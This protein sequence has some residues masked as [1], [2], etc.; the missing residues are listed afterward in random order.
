MAEYQVDN[1]QVKSLADIEKEPVGGKARWLH[2][3]IEIGLEVPEGLVIYPAKCPEKLEGHEK[4]EE[5]TVH[6]AYRD[7]G[8]GIAAVRSSAEDEDSDH[9]S[10][11]GQYETFL[12]VEGE[13][14]IARAVTACYESAHSERVS[15]Y[16]NEI[17][18]SGS[19]PQGA[20]HP[21]GPM[22][23][24]VQR[25]IEPAKA[26][27][28]F[29]V[30]PVTDS[31]ETLIIEAVSGTGDLLVSGTEAG[32]RYEI[33]RRTFTLN[34]G[35]V[36]EPHILTSAEIEKLTREALYAEEKL[37][38]SL[39]MEWAIDRSGTLFW[40]QARPITTGR[41][42]SLD[43][44][45]GDDELLTRCNIGEMLP[46]AATPLTLSVFAEPLDW[47]LQEMS[48]R[49]GVLHGLKK[50]PRYINH[51]ENHL[52]M[53]LT[54]MY[55]MA[56]RVAGATREGTELNIIG[57]ILPEHDIGPQDPGFF[58]VLNGF[59]YV[60]LLFRHN[61]FLKKITKT[62]KNFTIDLE[63]RSAYELYQELCTLQRSVLNKVYFYHYCVS[64]FSGAM[65]AILA[66]VIAGDDEVDSAA[67]SRMSLLLTD[68]P[69]IESAHILEAIEEIALS[70]EKSGNIDWFTA[71]PE[72]EILKWL[73]TDASGVTGTLFRQF[74]SRHGHR[75]IREA[76]L[77]S[78]DYETY[79]EELIKIIKD[80][81]ESNKTRKLFRTASLKAGKAE[82]K[83]DGTQQTED[84]KAVSPWLLK[85]AKTG[86]RQREFSKSMLI[87]AQHQ[88]KKG[89]RKLAEILVNENKLPDKDLIYFFTREEI[90]CLIQGEDRNLL[91]RK[92]K[93]RRQKLP[94]QMQLVFPEISRGRPVPFIR[95]SGN[96]S[97][98]KTITGTPVS[99][100]IT[101]GMV[102]IVNHI[103]EAYQLEP[104]EIMVA[105]FTDI[106]WT[107]FFSTISGLVTEIGGALSHGAVV[108]REYGLP[109]VSNIPGIINLL[110]TGM[111]I[112]LDG[113]AG[114]IH[115]LEDTDT[116]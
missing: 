15:S 88:F 8:G 27:V 68:I 114:T 66:A 100:G 53:N 26:G 62:A 42:D 37:G 49:E 44:P 58:R 13:K 79:P 71:A 11:A 77:R 38:R 21:P 70:I 102:R 87:L 115:I 104:G 22:A 64:A 65:N 30:D 25:M 20:Y 74:L 89:Y 50:P 107:P 35:G 98:G 41:Q 96:S 97:P 48:R 9:A 19:G 7:V 109:M 111:K 29:T 92:A 76:E 78:K 99:I 95:E 106:G 40:L 63:N 36:K 103:D 112:Q 23:V 73:E 85:Q 80:T 82:A 10:A 56:R 18:G 61:R 45:I 67:H 59:R 105:P 86:V 2:R 84:E 91:I 94:Y 52:F 32:Q 46:G 16:R 113:K 75:C 28:V 93:Q 57:R 116:E 12:R 34:E 60:L 108:A 5:K 54:S 47:G 3:L 43:T 90:G 33:D 24:I 17:A 4:P 83:A 6:K 110:E 55:V 69:D 39:D 51:V 101:E 81:V 31:N 14:A 72:T 1:F